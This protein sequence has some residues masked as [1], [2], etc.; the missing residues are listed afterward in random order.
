MMNTK[1]CNLEMVMIYKTDKE[2]S[3][4]T[5]EYNHIPDYKIRSLCL[6]IR[7]WKVYGAIMWTIIRYLEKA[8]SEI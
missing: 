1:L 6:E 4:I 3:F 8:Y 5:I 7:N 2:T